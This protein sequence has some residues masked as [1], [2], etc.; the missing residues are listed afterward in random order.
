MPTTRRDFLSRT[1][2]AAAGVAGSSVT[3]TANA[4]AKVDPLVQYPPP[5]K[6]VIVTRETGDSTR[7]PEAYAM[8]ERGA[9]TL[10]AA[11]HICRGARMIPA[12]T[13][14]ATAACPT[15]MA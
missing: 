6:P 4:E 9:D 3:E 1:A 7:K 10:D 2:L 13:A 8:L 5:K 14:S 12:I 11:L 15:K